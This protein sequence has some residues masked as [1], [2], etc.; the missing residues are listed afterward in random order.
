MLKNI[1]KSG[2]LSCAFCQG[3][4]GQPADERLSC[5]VCGGSGRV[6][7]RQPYNV[8]KNCGGT[9]KKKGATLYCLPCH[10]KG[11]AEEKKYTLPAKSPV[12]KTRKKIRKRKKSKFSRRKRVGKSVRKKEVKK[13]AKSKAKEIKA[14]AKKG[15]SSFLKGLLGTFKIL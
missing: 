2:K 14:T 15:K 13:P 6:R 3:K 9:G 4:G 10:G 8:C 12:S 7:V 5:L 1:E 11:F